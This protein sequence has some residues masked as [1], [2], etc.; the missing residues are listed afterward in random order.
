MCLQVMS[1]VVCILVCLGHRES[2]HSSALQSQDNADH[3]FGDRGVSVVFP[4]HIGS[5]V[6]A[7][8]RSLE[9]CCESLLGQGCAYV[10]EGKV[11]SVR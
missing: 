11:T 10:G 8:C 2:D 3:N 6:R 7:R 4:Y 9:C 1:A 5:L